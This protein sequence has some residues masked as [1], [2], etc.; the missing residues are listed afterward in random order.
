MGDANDM[1]PTLRDYVVGTLWFAVVSIT[2]P[3][4]AI[5][6]SMGYEELRRELGDYPATK[7]YCIRAALGF[8]LGV[9]TTLIV[10]GTVGVLN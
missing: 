5:W 3:I 9:L 1:K 2:F 10:L 6:A 7:L 8:V 4:Y